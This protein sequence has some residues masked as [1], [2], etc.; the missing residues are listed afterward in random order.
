VKWKASLDRNLITDVAGLRV[1]NAHCERLVSGVTALVGD[2]PMTAAAIVI[3]GGPGTREIDAIGLEGLVGAADGI[4]LSGGS[5]F[6]LDAATG[7]QSY[8]REKDRGFEVGTA[9]VPIVPQAILFD[10]LN[11]GD[12]N[13][14]RHS[15]YRDMGYEAASAA[16]S[17]F[18]IGAAGAGYGAS[19]ARSPGVRMRGGLGSTSQLI[20]HPSIESG[21]PITVGALT[22]VNAVGQVTIGDTRHFWAAPYER[23]SEFGG[24]GFPQQFPP[25]SEPAALKFAA[26]GNTTLAIVAT[27]AI[28]TQAECKR[29]AN[30][31]QAGLAR[32]IVPVFTAFDGDIVFAVSTNKIRLEATAL[33]LPHIGAAAARCLARAVAR[34]VFTAQ[35]ALPDGT[36]AYRDV[37]LA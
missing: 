3:G 6:G 25:E 20:A 21:T 17:N 18:E 12:K 7:V 22:A 11:G 30:M 24:L 4:V 13:W 1:G 35:G 36:P 26:P 31:A 9:R 34:G 23:G 16:N 33:A 10:L 32:A 28:L 19:V 8:L 15:P 29:L 5:A 2:A 14:G 37:F 27:D